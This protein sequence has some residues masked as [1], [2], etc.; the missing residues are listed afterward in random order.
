MYDWEK[1]KVQ[2]NY[3]YQECEDGI[4]HAFTLEDPEQIR[5]S[6]E[7]AKVLAELLDTTPDDDRFGWN[8]M[9]LELPRKTIDCF[10][11]RGRQELLAKVTLT[12]QSETPSCFYV[13]KIG[14]DAIDTVEV[15]S[16][17]EGLQLL[18]DY[19]KKILDEKGEPCAGYDMEFD[20]NDGSF[21]Y[22]DEEYYQTAFI[23]QSND[24]T[25]ARYTIE[26]IRR[27]ASEVDT[28]ANCYEYE[29]QDMQGVYD[30]TDKICRLADQLEQEIAVQDQL[31]GEKT[32][33]GLLS[34]IGRKLSADGRMSDSE[35]TKATYLLDELEQILSA[36][37][38]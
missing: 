9:F 24:F 33:P 4:Y 15:G 13:R 19:Y 18:K 35:L 10:R 37:S 16:W 20:E 3:G 21:L 11:E 2:L 1:N 34:E 29:L 5:D 38:E 25:G 26:Q 8:S 28:F 6:D 7:T 31:A 32:Y 23:I 17:E 14:S 22:T 12:P 30:T 36:Y 27:L